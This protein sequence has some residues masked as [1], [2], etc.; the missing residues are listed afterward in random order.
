MF[1][2]LIV[3]IAG[4]LF[5]AA[6]APLQ[7][8]GAL[9]GAAVPEDA[10]FVRQFGAENSLRLFGRT[11]D[12][13]DLPT[14]TFAAISASKLNGAVPGTYYSAVNSASVIAEPARE[15]DGKVHM[16]L[17]NASNAPAR[18]VIEAN[19]AEVITWTDPGQAAS[20][21]VNPVSV[22]LLVEAA[23]ASPSFEVKLRRGQNIS[24]LVTDNGIRVVPDVFG[25][26]IK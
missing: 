12:I 13:N 10:V 11:F 14:E 24:I 26:V 17:V 1:R 25:P 18:L 16:V 7:A 22:A 21:A 5:L 15:K 4:L 23:E 8:D 6:P 19:G 3:L 9:Y 20:R 2:S